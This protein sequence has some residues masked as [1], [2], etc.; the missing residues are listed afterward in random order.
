MQAEEA[1]TEMR[2][3]PLLVCMSL[4][5][6]ACST[7]RSLRTPDGT[8]VNVV[9]PPSLTDADPDRLATIWA[10]R[11][12]LT[13]GVLSTLVPPEPS[14][15]LWTLVPADSPNGP[16]WCCSES[17]N[18]SFGSPGGGGGLFGFGAGEEQLNQM[19]RLCGGIANSQKGA[20]RMRVDLYVAAPGA[21][22]AYKREADTMKPDYLRENVEPENRQ[23]LASIGDEQIL[24]RA[25]TVVNDQRLDNDDYELLFRRHNVI[26]RIELSYGSFSAPGKGPPEPL[27]EYAA[28]LD[29]NIEAAAQ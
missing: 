29:R 22:E 26:A 20:L 24:T 6:V 17:G 12:F 27:L 5:S 28:E 9:C 11:S 15:S 4:L 1:T 21:A 8:E 18:Q 13:P 7:G 10:D 25:L 2:L 23:L 19:G 16:V 3:L 14:N